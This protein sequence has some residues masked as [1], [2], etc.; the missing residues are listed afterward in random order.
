V[1]ATD[2]FDGSGVEAFGAPAEAPCLGPGEP[3]ELVSP[4]EGD[5]LSAR[6]IPLANPTVTQA[7]SKNAATISRNHQ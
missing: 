1:A 5:G 7:D 3:S 6:A 4:P 2:R